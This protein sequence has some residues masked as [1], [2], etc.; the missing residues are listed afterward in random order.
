[1]KD[2]KF[3]VYNNRRSCDLTY[4]INKTDSGWHISHIAING[5]CNPDGTPYLYNNFKQDNIN[6]PSGL[7]NSLS[8]LWEQIN[9]QKVKRDEAQEKLQ[10]LAD[11]VTTCEKSQPLWE[12]W[13]A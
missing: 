8:W 3:T 10:E 7:A 12:G 2:L 6:Y 4:R 11:W 1:M 5:N 9:S 13:T